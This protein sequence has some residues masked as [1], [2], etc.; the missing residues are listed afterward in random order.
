MCIYLF[1][2]IVYYIG[3]VKYI[4]RKRIT[5]FFFTFNLIYLL[6][7]SSS[8]IS[9]ECLLNFWLR[10]TIYRKSIAWKEKIIIFAWMILCAVGRQGKVGRLLWRQHTSSNEIYH[11]IAMSEWMNKR[12]KPTNQF[13]F[14]QPW[15][16]IW[17]EMSK[18]FTYIKGKYSTQFNA[19]RTVRRFTYIVAGFYNECWAG[20]LGSLFFFF[21]YFLAFLVENNWKACCN[22]FLW[23]L[24][25]FIF[26]SIVLR[27]RLFF[28]CLWIWLFLSDV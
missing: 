16:E 7:F 27:M 1:L 13:D 23:S 11:I 10:F 14:Q 8:L 15:G 18:R 24:W 5:Q 9:G 22:L 6:F 26:L 4:N 17:M 21:P 3:I 2:Y 20:F 12:T 28:W 19:T 25:E